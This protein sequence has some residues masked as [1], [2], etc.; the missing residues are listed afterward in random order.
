MTR[1]ATFRSLAV[2][3]SGLSAGMGVVSVTTADPGPV[4]VAIGGNAV[5]PPGQGTAQEQADGVARA[6]GPVADLVASGVAVV[7]THGNGPQVGNLLLKNLLARDLVPPMPLDWCVAQTQATIGSLIVA[8]LEDEFALRGLDRPVVPVLTRVL[9]AGDDPAWQSPTKPI[10]PMLDRVQRDR[11]RDVPVPGRWSEIAPGKWRLL[12]PSPEPHE[13]LDLAPAE[14]LLAGG[15]VVVAAGG[16]GVPVVRGADGVTRGVEAVVDKDLASCRLAI[17]IG[18]DRLVVLTDVDGVAMHFGGNRE[19]WLDRVDVARLRGLQRSGEF[20]PGSM[21]P[22]VE[23]VCRF[24]ESTGR[25]AQIGAIGG[26][27]LLGDGGTTVV[28]IGPS[29]TTCAVP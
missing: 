9:V 20:P 3:V 13:I 6:L 1:R 10:G 27:S 24:V 29:A 12:V 17:A 23:A 26:R 21:K 18:A 4:V 14:L 2:P 28:P 22:K 5:A 15:A 19:C 8:A 16:G 25:S 11:L 7:L